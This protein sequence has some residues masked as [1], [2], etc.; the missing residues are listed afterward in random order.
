MVGAGRRTPVES[1]AGGAI[2]VDGDADLAAAVLTALNV[3]P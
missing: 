3:V 1:I 2:E